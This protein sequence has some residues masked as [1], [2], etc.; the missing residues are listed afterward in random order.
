MSIAHGSTALSGI[1]VW[2]SWWNPKTEPYGLLK[3]KGMKEYMILKQLK[4]DF[5]P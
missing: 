2:I 3:A 1:S 4:P 5:P